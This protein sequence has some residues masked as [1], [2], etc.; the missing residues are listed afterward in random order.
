MAGLATI[1]PEFPIT[2]WDRLVPQAEMTLNMLQNSRINCILSAYAYLFGQYNFNVTPMAP[3]GTLVA[4]YVKPE[5][6]TL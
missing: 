3:P 5:I 6:G 1:H 2:E 4:V